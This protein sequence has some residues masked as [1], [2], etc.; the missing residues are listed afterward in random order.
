M[1]PKDGILWGAYIIIYIK[2]I[3]DMFMLLTA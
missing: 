2:V 3:R 1:P